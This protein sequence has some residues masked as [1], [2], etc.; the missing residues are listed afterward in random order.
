LGITLAAL[1]VLVHASADE[2]FGRILAEA[3]AA[4]LPAVAFASGAAPEI[5]VHERTG[6]LVTP[7][8]PEALAA[9]I[10]RLLGDPVLRRSLGEAARHHAAEHFDVSRLTREVEAV[11]ARAL[12]S[13]V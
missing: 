6:L 4:G 12:G 5:V 2:P 13:D 1:D 8:D 10:R 7:G 11:F 9:A 3:A